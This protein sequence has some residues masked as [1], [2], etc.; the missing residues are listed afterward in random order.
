[1]AALG[2]HS[3]SARTPASLVEGV[4]ITLFLASAVGCS[5]S[6]VAQT[7]DGG[8]D[9]AVGDG[10]CRDIG[11]CLEGTRWNQTACKCLPLRTDASVDSEAG[12]QAEGGTDVSQCCST[13]L[14]TCDCFQ[15]GGSPN[16]F[17]RCPTICD[18]P[19]SGWTDTVDN[20]GCPVLVWTD[21]GGPSCNMPPE[22]GVPSHAA[23]DA[24]ADL[25]SDTSTGEAGHP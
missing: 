17:G 1:M 3:G 20:S 19:P 15:I 18:A 12:T 21:R 23:V 16:E 24:Q 10:I 6:P 11:A 22:A 8:A 5:S 7:S 2:R 9:D 13:G 14:A 4:L 25:A